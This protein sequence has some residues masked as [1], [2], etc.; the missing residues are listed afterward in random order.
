M[1][2]IRRVQDAILPINRFAIE[3]VQQIIRDQFHDMTDAK[4]NE[5][6][7]KLH[8]PVK[9]DFMSLLFVCD[10]RKG[11]V[12]GFVLFS[13]E[14]N[15]KFGFLDLIALSNATKGGGV[16]AALYQRVR[17]ECVSLGFDWLFFESM[18]DQGQDNPDKEVL[19]SNKKRM[20]F[21]EQQG[22]RPVIGTLYQ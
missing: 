15:L 22:A 9:F 14:P 2:R 20:R 3:Q 13:A 6:P 12:R 7:E 21:Y 16:G 17:E 18:S 11:N 10:D 4:I 1:F 19:K 5:I 8:N